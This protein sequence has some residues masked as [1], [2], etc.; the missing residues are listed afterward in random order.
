MFIPVRQ[1]QYYIMRWY[2]L[3]V[4]TSLRYRAF[5]YYASTS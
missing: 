4:N 5:Y 1:V 2:Y 3:Y